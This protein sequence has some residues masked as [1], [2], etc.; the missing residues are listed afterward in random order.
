MV[1]NG[2]ALLCKQTHYDKQQLY[3]LESLEKAAITYI[4]VIINKTKGNFMSH[5]QLQEKYNIK[6]NHIV[7]LQIPSSIQNN[8]IKTLKEIKYIAHL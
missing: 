6:T 7:T 4:N 5:D 1:L 2:T 3:I 8:W